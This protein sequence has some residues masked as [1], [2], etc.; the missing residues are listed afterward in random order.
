MVAPLFYCSCE[1]TNLQVAFKANMFQLKRS[2]VRNEHAAVLK[3]G[4]KLATERLSVLFT[5]C[6]VKT[7]KRVQ[8]TSIVVSQRFQRKRTTLF[9]IDRRRVCKQAE[10]RKVGRK[11]YKDGIYKMENQPSIS[12]LKQ[13]VN[14]F[15]DEANKIF[16]F[17]N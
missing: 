12:G 16:L 10:S 7:S 8:V 6:V 2:L 9:F 17:L 5:A 3:R 11:Q 13:I 1:L 15:I 14:R 4:S